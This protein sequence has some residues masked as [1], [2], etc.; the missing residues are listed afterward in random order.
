MDFRDICETAWSYKLK[1]SGLS[2]FYNTNNWGK[3][4]ENLKGM[5]DMVWMILRG[6]TPKGKY[7]KI[8]KNHQITKEI[9]FIY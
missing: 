4:E 9:S 1:F 2:S 7:H 5:G 3:F 8:L 6:I